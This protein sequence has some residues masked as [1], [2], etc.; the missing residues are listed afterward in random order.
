MR[1]CLELYTDPKIF[2]KYTHMTQE[3]FDMLLQMV[4]PSIDKKDTVMHKSIPA[5]LCIIKMH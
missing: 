5:G 4:K 3:I 2:R 1:N